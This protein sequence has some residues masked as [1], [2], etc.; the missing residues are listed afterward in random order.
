MYISPLVTEILKSFLYL[1]KVKAV[2]KI[3]TNFPKT[4]LISGYS[5]Y[6]QHK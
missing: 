2:W 3:S 5:M 4:K 6:D 1:E